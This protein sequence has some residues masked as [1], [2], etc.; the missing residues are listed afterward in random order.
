MKVLLIVTTKGTTEHYDDVIEIGCDGKRLIWVDSYRGRHYM[1]VEFI[2][3][4]SIL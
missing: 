3:R 4:F 1:P 2:E